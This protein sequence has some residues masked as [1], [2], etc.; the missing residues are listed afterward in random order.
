MSLIG[1]S[2]SRG[3]GTFEKKGSN[4]SRWLMM[5]RKSLINALI[6][7]II[8]TSIQMTMITTWI[9]VTKNAEDFKE[10]ALQTSFLWYHHKQHD[11]K[12]TNFQQSITKQSKVNWREHKCDKWDKSAKV[13]LLFFIL[14]EFFWLVQFSRKMEV[15]IRKYL[16]YKNEE[17]HT[18][19]KVHRLKGHTF[20]TYFL[21]NEWNSL[22]LNIRWTSR[23]QRKKL[24][25][26]C[27]FN[28]RTKIDR[29]RRKTSHLRWIES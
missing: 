4:W 19:D 26:F 22:P 7:D 15:T 28:S 16:L 17:N 14:Y 10:N 3:K 21:Q 25:I 5:M 11:I 18:V 8:K 23:Y 12:W 24:Y 1:Y 9:L 13:P 27:I 20:T 29:K 2:K 6:L